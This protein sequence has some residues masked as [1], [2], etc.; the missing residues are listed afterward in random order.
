M[1]TIFPLGYFTLTLTRVELIG[2]LNCGEDLE[3]G[4]RCSCLGC[5]GHL[6]EPCLRY[7][8]TRVACPSVFFTF[9]NESHMGESLGLFC[10][11]QK[12]NPVDQC[13]I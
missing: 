3:G 11:I 12:E 7:L 5:E 1:R 4:G 10:V 8:I 9:W 13:A 6:S 2:G